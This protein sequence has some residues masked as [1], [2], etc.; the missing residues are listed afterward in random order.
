[1]VAV[2]YERSFNYRALTGNLMFWIGGRLREVVAHGGSTELTNCLRGFAEH[3]RYKKI[4]NLWT[5]LNTRNLHGG[6]TVHISLKAKI[7]INVTDSIACAV[8]G[9]KANMAN[10]WANICLNVWKGII[11]TV[12]LMKNLKLKF[13][14]RETTSLLFYSLEVKSVFYRPTSGWTM[15][16][17]ALFLTVLL[18][19]SRTSIPSAVSC[20]KF[21]RWI[22]GLKRD[23][24]GMRYLSLEY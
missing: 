2:A 1:M 23:Q 5:P 20:Q 18:F 7:N 10:R 19:H 9:G 16:G 3:N 8:F 24:N 11:H 21:I 4:C 15:G 13:C 6:N 22:L 12:P 17:V 14:T